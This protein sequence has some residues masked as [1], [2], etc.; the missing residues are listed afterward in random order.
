M[1]SLNKVFRNQYGFGFAQLLIV[2]PIVLIVMASATSYFYQKMMVN[3]QHRAREN[4]A[5]HKQNMET[6]LNNAAVWSELIRANPDFE[7]L[8]PISTT[9]CKTLRKTE[10]VIVDFTGAHLSGGNSKGFRTNG[11]SCEAEGADC[12]VKWTYYWRPM[13]SL[14]SACTNPEVEITGELRSNT[15]ELMPM[16]Y[17]NFKVVLYKKIY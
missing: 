3:S 13:C 17:D 10:F 14:L 8:S 6:D 1:D 4:F 9:P 2:L 15:P 11:Q 7:C 5:I 12:P 16:N